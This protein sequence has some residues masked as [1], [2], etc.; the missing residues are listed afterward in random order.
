MTDRAPF[1]NRLDAYTDEQTFTKWMAGARDFDLLG[2]PH[3]YR[4][5]LERILGFPLWEYTAEEHYDGAYDGYEID[6]VARGHDGERFVNV[7]IEAQ[8]DR[9]KS[10]AQ[11]HLGRLFL[12]GN[13]VDADVLVWLT[14][15][16]LGRRYN[17]TVAWLGP[18]LSDIQFHMIGTDIVEKG[19]GPPELSFE[20]IAPGTAT[21]TTT[22]DTALAQRQHR[23]WA[24]LVDST[25]ESDALNQS[26]APA[27]GPTHRQG[28]SIAV[29]GI[30]VELVIDSQSNMSKVRIRFASG[31]PTTI[32][33]AL[34]DDRKSIEQEVASD[35]GWSWDDPDT[36]LPHTVTVQHEDFSLDDPENWDD[37]QTWLNLV[38]NRLSD[39]IS[40]RSE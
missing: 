17:E 32:Y 1:R 20:R 35:A 9:G 33:P 19:D 15:A 2:S 3:P 23:F 10:S 28:R 25:N 21:E 18:R 6:I 37:H 7:V 4:E 8:F 27:P 36:T 14:D 16:E 40:A 39:L 11:N 31:A 22:S 30:T 5:E 38:L 13:L 29:T 34:Y 26:V 12:Y 24:E